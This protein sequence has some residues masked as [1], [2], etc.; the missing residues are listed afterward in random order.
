MTE[1]EWWAA[2]NPYDLLA[3]LE[4]RVSPR[5][6]RLFAA[7]ICRRVGESTVATVVEH[8]ADGE[9]GPNELG[10]A[11]AATEQ[12]WRQGHRNH[13]F[14]KRSISPTG[15]AARVAWE[16]AQPIAEDAALG[17]ARESVFELREQQC[18]YLRELIGNPFAPVTVR[19]E[20][21]AWENG[22]VRRIAQAIYLERAFERLPLLADALTDADCSC[23]L[24]LRHLREPGEHLLGCWGLDVLLGKQ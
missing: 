2:R 17:A 13:Y 1:V 24:L 4:G 12:R 23:E 18:A 21:L 11:R 14:K 10:S 20:W 3:H 22:L 15:R 8:Y 16:A 6:L 9:A 7:A 5:K 19:S